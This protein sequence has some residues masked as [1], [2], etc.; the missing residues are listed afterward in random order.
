MRQR[1]IDRYAQGA[2]NKLI[3][4]HHGDRENPA[5]WLPVLQQIGCR[6]HSYHEPGGQL[7]EYAP[8]LEADGGGIVQWNT[9]A[10]PPMQARVLCHEGAHHLMWPLVSGFLFGEWTRANYDDDPLDV[11]QRIARRVEHLCFGG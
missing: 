8:T 7:G 5:T 11:R 3:S 6:V 9:A 2:A 1:E 4:L 10:T